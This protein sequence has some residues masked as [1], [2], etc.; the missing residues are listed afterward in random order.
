MTLTI[1]SNILDEYS[2]INKETASRTTRAAALL[3]SFLLFFLPLSIL[4][5]NAAVCE[6]STSHLFFFTLSSCS[7]PDHPV[8]VWHMGPFKTNPRSHFPRH[9]QLWTLMTKCSWFIR[10]I[11][12]AMALPDWRRLNCITE[13]KGHWSASHW[14]GWCWTPTC[15]SPYVRLASVAEVTC[16]SAH[17][18]IR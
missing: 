11:I 15:V 1:H 6:L 18:Q 14:S 10:V 16:V 12:T 4:L 3:S 8:L 13:E 7:W 2:H 9:I 5:L 17:V